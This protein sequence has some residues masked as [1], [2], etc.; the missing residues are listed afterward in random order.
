MLVV[1]YAA[2]SCIQRQLLDPTKTMNL[3]EAVHD[4]DSLDEEGTIY[5]A[6]P[7]TE[8]SEVVVA[9]EPESG[10]LPD[11][12]EGLGLN[13]FLEVVA[14]REVMEDW[15]SSLEREPTTQQRC[16]RLIEYAIKD[17]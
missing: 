9:R 6:E 8:K 17:A 11:E 14:A 16:S 12:A 10:G 13:Y 1:A 3:L 2:A 5:A 15:I 7:W 4:L